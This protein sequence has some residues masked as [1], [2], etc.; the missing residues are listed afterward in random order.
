MVGQ[1]DFLSTYVSPRYGLHTDR[2]ERVRAYLQD[3]SSRPHDI[4]LAHAVCSYG[5]G[6]VAVLARFRYTVSATGTPQFSLM[7]AIVSASTIPAFE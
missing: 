6:Y 5:E 2:G 4:K 1:S 3:F 7:S